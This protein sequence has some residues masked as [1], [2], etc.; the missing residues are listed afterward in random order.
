RFLAWIPFSYDVIGTQLSRLEIAAV[1]RELPR[2]LRPYLIFEISGLPHGVPQSRLSELVGSVRPFCRG[3]MAQVPPRTVN[4]GAYMGVGLQGVGISAAG[5]FA[6]E[7]V[8]SFDA[9][10]AATRRQ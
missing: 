9:L 2:D 7:T 4:Y 6:K 10:A 3:V 5:G 1:C 8:A